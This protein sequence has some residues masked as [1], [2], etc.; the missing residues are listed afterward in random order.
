[1]WR[2][3]LVSC[4][5]PVEFFESFYVAFSYNYLRI[6]LLPYLSLITLFMRL[7]GAKLLHHD[8]ESLPLT[9]GA[10]LISMSLGNLLEIP[11]LFL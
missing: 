8:T 11:D 6:Q 1:M 3:R 5:V 9:R 7:V 10:E 4:S 2:A